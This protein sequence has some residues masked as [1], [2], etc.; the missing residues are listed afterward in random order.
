MHQILQDYTAINWVYFYQVRRSVVAEWFKSVAFKAGVSQR[1]FESGRRQTV[2]VTAC[3]LWQGSL[4]LSATSPMTTSDAETDVKLNIYLFF[5]LQRIHWS[6]IILNKLHRRRRKLNET[7][8]NLGEFRRTAANLLATIFNHRGLSLAYFPQNVNSRETQAAES[9][10][11][12][13]SI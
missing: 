13:L 3:T 2:T 4:N 5:Y 1:R 7:G 9:K 8:K 10:Q 12:L 6:M 11:N